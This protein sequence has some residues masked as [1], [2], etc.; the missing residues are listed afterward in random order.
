MT[1]LMSNDVGEE[2]VVALVAAEIWRRMSEFESV[3]R[4]MVISLTG[5]SLLPQVVPRLVSSWGRVRPPLTLLSSAPS[6]SSTT[7]FAAPCWYLALTSWQA[8]QAVL[9]RPVFPPALRPLTV[10]LTASRWV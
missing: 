8:A 1:W 2:K 10:E 6:V 5:L 3:P 9:Y 7:R 4:P